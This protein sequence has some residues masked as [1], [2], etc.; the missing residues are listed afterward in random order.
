MSGEGSRG[1]GYLYNRGPHIFFLNRGPLG[2]NPAN[3]P[4]S[5]Q[6]PLNQ[7]SSLQMD[8]CH[9][10]SSVAS[11]QQLRSASRRLIVDPRCRLSTTGRRAFSVVSPSVGVEYCWT[12]CAI[13]LLAFGQL[14][15][16]SCSLR[17]S[18]YS[19]LEVLRSCA[20]AIYIHWH[21]KAHRLASPIRCF[22]S[23]AYGRIFA[24]TTSVVN[25]I[26]KFLNKRIVVCVEDR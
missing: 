12:T 16:R 21:W 4:I 8:F 13:L 15:K 17:T 9:P 23:V 25:Y 14:W 3:L 24:F 10:T 19:A 6:R 18:A 20:C 11:W 5:S 22:G 7:Y 1:G 26:L 2:V